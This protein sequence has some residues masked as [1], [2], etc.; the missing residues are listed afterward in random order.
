MASLAPCRNIETETLTIGLYTK[1]VESFASCAEVIRLFRSIELGILGMKEPIEKLPLIL[2][3]Y[4]N[5]EIL[6]LEE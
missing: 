2:L 1:E 5:P 4:S 3:R 6:D